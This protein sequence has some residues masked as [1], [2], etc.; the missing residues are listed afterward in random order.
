MSMDLTGI[1]NVNEY[2]TNHYLDSIFEENASATIS[3]WRSEAKESQNIKTPWAM[4]RENARQY[5]TAHDRYQRTRFDTQTL[6]SIKDL[7]DSYL[8]S[9]GY[10]TA[11]PETI[12]IDESLSVPI[13]LEIKKKNG[14]PLLWVLL[15]ASFNQEEGIME[16]RCFDSDT[17]AEEGQ[18]SVSEDQMIKIANEELATKIL[19]TINEPP[20]FLLFIGMNQI[21]L[22]DRN[23]WNEKRYLQ[24]ELEVIFSRREETT[25]Q[26][27][28]VLLHKESLCPEE[29]KTLLD[30][31]DENSQ[32]HA[33][34]VSEDLKYALRESI[35]LLGNEVLFDMSHR[36][37]RDT[38]KEPV[39]SGQLTVECL[40]FMYRMLFVLFIESRPELGYSPIKA[41][42]Y[43]SA[44]SLESLR[45]ITDNVREDIDEVGDGYF[46]HETLA[47]LYDLIYKG[48]PGTEEDLLKYSGEDS[49]HDMFVISPLKAH[50]FDP[51]FTPMITASKIRNRVMLRI[52]EL[53]SLT[54]NHNGRNRRRG[55]ISYSN[56]G[57]N[58]M[59]AVY[60]ALL[61]YRGFIAEHDLY[62]VT[63][64][65]VNF[66]ELDVGYF[67][68]ESELDQYT[69]AERVRYA[70]GVRPTHLT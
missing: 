67:V 36:Q 68:P 57:I 61:S 66:N 28:S 45:D 3:S 7:A 18:A 4:L 42:S 20:R 22:I 39:D 9:L 24:F 70:I 58:Q 26:A 19:F 51:E 49:L 27:M 2:Y 33:S 54:R 23:K 60:E 40:R 48:Y 47:K 6:I 41:Q 62:E 64:V 53:M 31:L 1:T 34:G 55:R 12:N 50:I 15:F 44:Y 37:K 17:L 32:R 46:L 25:L 11:K 69:E 21:A 63:R 65:G 30:D 29:G 56:L 59:G 16:S 43:M 52:V 10:Q 35:E 14:A 13:Y 8:L 38:E 5:Y